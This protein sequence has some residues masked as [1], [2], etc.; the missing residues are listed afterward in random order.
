MSAPSESIESEAAAADVTADVAADVAAAADAAAAA[1]AAA[2][3]TAAGHRPPELPTIPQMLHHVAYITYDSAVTTDFYTRVMGMPLVNAVMDDHLPS[4]G[5]RTPYFH[6][7]FRMADG[8]TLAFFESPGLPPRPEPPT[9][10][11]NNFN[12][13]ALEVPTRADV[14]RWRDWL[15]ANDV[16]HQVVDHHIIYSIYFQDPNN[17]RLEITATLDP[18]WNA[19]EEV[20]AALL[21]E[22]V[23]TR[24]AAAASGQ[25]VNEALRKLVARHA[26]QAQFK[27]QH[28]K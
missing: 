22:W 17:V 28:A 6:T 16:E 23:E 27:G 13:I 8:S 26:H 10:A 24:A 3:V 14:D 19:Q 11:F 7:F 12:H 15:Q 4:T 18:S 20:G 2:D 5:D 1:A 25:D 9:P 21:G